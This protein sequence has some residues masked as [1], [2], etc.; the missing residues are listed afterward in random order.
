[1]M[2]S[3]QPGAQENDYERLH[4]LKT[5]MRCRGDCA[6]EKTAM[7]RQ[8]QKD[9]QSALRDRLQNN[10]VRFPS[11]SSILGGTPSG[12]NASICRRNSAFS[13]SR[14]FQDINNARTK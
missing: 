11:L 12:S 8:N 1:M 6:S 2:E 14:G 10:Q 4:Y 3:G 13:R 7:D 9:P 5:R